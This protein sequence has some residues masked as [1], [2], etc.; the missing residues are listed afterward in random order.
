MDVRRSVGGNSNKDAL[1]SGWLQ[2]QQADVGH[3]GHGGGDQ[4]GDD[5]KLGF[6]ERD[7]GG[8]KNAGDFHAGRGGLISPRDPLPD[9]GVE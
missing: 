6:G 1:R 7:D 4:G 2:P 9:R 8:A 5:E 3:F